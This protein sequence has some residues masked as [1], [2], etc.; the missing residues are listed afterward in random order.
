MK[1]KLNYIL[2]IL[3]LAATAIG[4]SANA[5]SVRE[6][7]KLISEGN[8]LFTERKYSEAAKKYEEALG[9]N[10]LSA[11]SRYNLG[12][13]QIKQVTN[14]QDTTPKSKSLLDGARKNLESVAALA[15]EKPGLASK[16]NYNLGNL[17]YNTKEYKNA[18][19]YYKQALRINPEDE[20]A[21]KNLRIAQKQLQNQD[22]NKDQNQ[23][24]QN[25]D[26]QQD[27]DQNKDQDKN[28][29]QNKDQQQN[30]DQNKKDERKDNSISQQTANQ[31][32]QAMDN[33]ENQ[34]RARVNRANKG[35]KTNGSGGSRKRW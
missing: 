23:Q 8:K 24:D 7:R 20:S 30:Q 25:K 26:Q 15:K 33:K 10:S 5:Q 28:Q 2:P 18:I 12:L 21:R 29:N 13:A 1:L 3:L 17:E 22:Q 35:E 27:Q 16:A 34:T 4:L 31:I 19:E 32:L 6:E 11:V 14:P 9:V